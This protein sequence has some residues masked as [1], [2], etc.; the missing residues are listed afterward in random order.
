VPKRRLLVCSCAMRS[1]RVAQY[2]A[3]EVCKRCATS[4]FIHKFIVLG[5]K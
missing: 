3:D 2:A 1:K 4:M 5:K